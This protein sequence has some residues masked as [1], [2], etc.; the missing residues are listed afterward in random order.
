MEENPELNDLIRLL[1]GALNARSGML[2]AGETNALRLFNGF[3]EG[4]PGLAVDLYDSTLVL[5]DHLES[6]GLPE[7]WMEEIRQFYLQQIPQINS[8][9]RKTRNSTTIRQRSGWL[10]QGGAAAESIREYGVQYAVNLMLNRDASFYL[11]TRLLRRWLL[12][13]SRGL[14]V[15]NCFAYTGS[16]GVAALAGG[17]GQV[18]QTDLNRNFLELARRSCMLNRLDLGKMKLRAV[19]FFAEVG[20]LKRKGMLYDLVLLDPPF[21]S[22]TEKGRVDQQESS[23]RLINKVR[24]LVNH[25]GRIAAVNNS[26]YLPGSEYMHS[27]EELCLDGYLELEEIIPVPADVTGFAETIRS[28]PPVSPAPFNHPTKIAILRVKR[29]QS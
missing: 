19:D 4:F 7:V 10:A 6:P 26:L 27:L 18:L 13:H 2:H 15:L 23:A 20:Q 8:V 16:L 25:N 24:P 1:E 11:D 17:A 14:Q 22:V 9:V 5:F 21:F 29:K 12:D 28:A 3:Y